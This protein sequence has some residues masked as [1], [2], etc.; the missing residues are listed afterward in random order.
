MWLKLRL[1]GRD[2]VH[3]TWYCR[4]QHARQLML[5]GKWFF[6]VGGGI[7]MPM[8]TGRM[9]LISTKQRGKKA[10]KEKGS[11]I[12]AT[13]VWSTLISNSLRI[14]FSFPY[15]GIYVNIPYLTHVHVYITPSLPISILFWEKLRDVRGFEPAYTISYIYLS[16]YL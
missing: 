7:V 10:W 15:L 5:M 14:P 9:T 1:G 8:W 12:D 3:S 6:S 16:I 2:L 11:V 4:C 13:A